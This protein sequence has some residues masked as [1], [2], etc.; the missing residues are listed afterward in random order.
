MKALKLSSDPNE[1]K[2]LKA[3]CSDIMTTAGRIKSDTNWK[4]TAESLSLR[5]GKVDISQ[6]AAEVVSAQ[7]TSAG[8]ED[9]T[10]QSSLSRHGLSSTTAPVD[11]VSIPSGKTSPSSILVT[12]PSSYTQQFSSFE[13][14]TRREPHVLFI[15]L[16][17]DQFS[18]PS[19]FGPSAPTDARHEDRPQPKPNSA[20]DIHEA[21][22]AALST[23]S[24]QSPSVPHLDSRAQ[25]EVPTS[26][27][28][29]MAPYSH[30]HRLVEPASSRKRS[31]R[32][33]IILLKASMVNG[34]KCPPWD[35]TPLPNEFVTL[36]D[37]EL[38]V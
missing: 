12:G 22:S 10:S 26:A 13:S 29:S 25:H 27:T 8:L 4:P 11:N 23:L 31:K 24:L 21:S 6:W 30:I 37:T 9:I 19:T 16:S 14:E 17:D 2:L 34:F 38:F 7:S 5:P 33:D 32:E 20:A 18:S 1:K 28:P 35:K 15:N 3:Q 36:K